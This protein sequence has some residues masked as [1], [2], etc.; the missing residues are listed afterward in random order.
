MEKERLMVKHATRRTVTA[1]LVVLAAGS[2]VIGVRAAQDSPAAPASATQR[3]RRAPIRGPIAAKVM[4]RL[5]D[6]TR[7]K[8][9]AILAGDSVAQT[10]EISG[11]RLTR[12]EKNVV[13]AQRGAEQAAVRMSLESAGGRV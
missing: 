1:S 6:E 7:V 11:R 3:F 10:Q 8:V 12:Q 5:F 4:P 2:I 13:K 9:V